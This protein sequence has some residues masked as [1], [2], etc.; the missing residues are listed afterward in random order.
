MTAPGQKLIDRPDDF[1]R[2]ASAPR[3]HRC[4]STLRRADEAVGDAGAIDVV[5]PLRRRRVIVELLERLLKRGRSRDMSIVVP[6]KVLKQ[7][8]LFGIPAHDPFR[9]LSG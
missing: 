7:F 5:A 8:A 9:S 6:S 2:S 1:V 3:T 4:K